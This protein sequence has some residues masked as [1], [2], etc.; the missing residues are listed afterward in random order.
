MADAARELALGSTVELSD[1]T[2][3]QLVFTMYS[4]ALIEEEYGS[5]SEIEKVFNEGAQG[6]LIRN[7]AKL[8][9]YAVI[10]NNDREADLTEDTDA[11]LKL[12]PL[13]NMGAAIL[14]V[15]DGLSEGFQQLQ[16]T[17][18]GVPTTPAASSS[19]GASSSTSGAP[20]SARRAAA[21]GK[22]RTRK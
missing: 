9:A 18:A 7:I 5:V 21:S 4:L 17:I 8:M 11:L 19:P 13:K 20:R 6:K 2:K 1:G 16:G 10:D 12:I 14:A 22:P 15:R 3:I